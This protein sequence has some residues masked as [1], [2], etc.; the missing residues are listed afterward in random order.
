MAL[1]GPKSVAIYGLHSCSHWPLFAIAPTH[2]WLLASQGVSF[3]E[4]QEGLKCDNQIK[5]LFFIFNTQEFLS[6]HKRLTSF[7][8]SGPYQGEPHTIPPICTTPQ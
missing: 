1:T 3:T 5:Q 2:E 7:N 4:V 8:L 6:E